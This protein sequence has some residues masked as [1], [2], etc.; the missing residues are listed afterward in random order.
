MRRNKIITIRVNEELYNNVQRIINEKT[1]QYTINYRN[2]RKTL[3]EY[4]GKEN[5]MSIGKFSVSDLIE[6]AF[7]EFIESNTK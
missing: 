7:K 4:K 3:Y 5:K 1:I 2:S 6:N